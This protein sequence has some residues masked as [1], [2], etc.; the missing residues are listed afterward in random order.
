MATENPK[1]TVARTLIEVGTV[2][3]FTDLFTKGKLPVKVLAELADMSYY[4]LRKKV[5]HLNSME[6]NDIAKIAN[7]LRV[8]YKTIRDLVRVD[9][10]MIKRRQ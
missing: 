10:G 9:L 8:D 7:A 3:S 2:T 5:E 4:E 6:K 1:I